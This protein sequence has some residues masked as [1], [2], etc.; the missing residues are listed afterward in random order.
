[1]K[2]NRLMGH[3]VTTQSA[4]LKRSV[5]GE[6]QADCYLGDDESDPPIEN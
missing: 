1:M 3:R 6:W 4:L 2:T 5:M